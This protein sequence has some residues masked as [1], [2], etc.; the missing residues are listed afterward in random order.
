[1]LPILSEGFLKVYKYQQ[2]KRNKIKFI[3]QWPLKEKR[4]DSHLLHQGGQAFS[5]V[6]QRKPA[7]CPC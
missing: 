2:K 6:L 1:M 7:S 5:I 4:V 3:K